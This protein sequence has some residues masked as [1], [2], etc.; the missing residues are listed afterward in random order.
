MAFSKS[1]QAILKQLFSFMILSFLSSGAMAQDPNDFHGLSR[2]R[3]E[4]TKISADEKDG[5]LGDSA[6]NSDRYDMLSYDLDLRIDPSDTSC[7]GSVVMVFSSVVSDL[8]EFVFDFDT[9]FPISQIMHHGSAV[10]FNQMTGDSVVVQ[11]PVPL[12]MGQTDSLVVEYSGQPEEPSWER[13]LIFRT[14]SFGGYTAPLVANMSEP[15]YAK[16]WWPCKDRPDD[17][18]FTAVSLTVPDTLIG[19]SNGTLVAEEIPEAGW[20]TFHWR[21]SYPM[22]TYLVSVAISNYQLQSEECTTSGG[23]AV[24]LRHWVLPPDYDDAL[25][26]FAPVCEMMD[27]CEDKFSAYPFLGEKYGHAEFLWNGAMEHTTVTS[28]G[29]GSLTG[30]GTH[31]WLIVHELG[32]QWFGD[33]LTPRKWA[34]IWL[35]EGFATYTEALWEEHKGG[36][37]AYL[38]YLDLSRSEAV[39]EFQG[40]VY[41]P[42]PVFPGR[43]IYDKGSW[44]VHMLRERLGDAVFFTLLEEWTGS[45][46]RPGGTVITEEFI[47]LAESVSGQELGNFFWPYLENTQ[48][49]RIL[50]EYSI[51]EG[52]AGT[53]T[54]LEV[55]L[56]QTQ[57]QIFDNIFPI[58]V[59]T[60]SGTEEFRVSLPGR[61]VQAEFELNAPIES[62]QLDP[63]SSVLWNAAGSSGQ[64]EGLS[65]A[66]PN[67]SRDHYVYL[68]YRLDDTA[69][70]VFRFFDARG[71]EVA[72]RNLGSISP[73]VG[74]NEYVWD[75]KDNRGALVS[76]GV[77]WAT[78]EI[79][80]K[81]SVLKISIVH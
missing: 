73:E 52:D 59:T 81:R 60:G 5:A 54:H 53:D 24:P 40:P 69:N 46:G 15:A 1:K 14:Y 13:G 75:E 77:Y 34:D 28:I 17:K 62:V 3:F 47:A 10:V 74:F 22:P 11:L 43:V 19:V 56:R 70:V 39:W 67:P 2:A 80:G 37:E 8:Q 42:V 4:A 41:D 30:A 78:M 25:V 63:E 7:V 48:L 45:G 9:G 51:S 6:A 49:P 38:E 27:F 64:F 58:S 29:R 76:S 66:Y 33:S 16:Y 36:R 72:R 44:I 35:N 32:H 71:R 61:S 65:L 12:V 21:E 18:A 79:D 26:D 57:G 20:K 68:R 23:S 50:F 31:D 55:S